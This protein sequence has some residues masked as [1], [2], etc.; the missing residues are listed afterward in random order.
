VLLRFRIIPVQSV[1]EKGGGGKGR[2]GRFIDYLQ[3]EGGNASPPQLVA[4]LPDCEKKGK[5]RKGREKVV[6]RLQFAEQKGE[7]GGIS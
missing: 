6:A 3:G 1:T 5:K 2:G 7:K 4:S